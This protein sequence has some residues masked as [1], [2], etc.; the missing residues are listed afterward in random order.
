MQPLS[1]YTK[2]ELID[3]F[4]RDMVFEISSP[5]G[6]WINFPL[7]QAGYSFFYGGIIGRDK[8]TTT[9]TY[10]YGNTTYT[11]EIL[12]DS[13][14][15][16][17][18]CHLS[19]TFNNNQFHRYQMVIARGFFY[20]FSVTLQKNPSYRHQ[21]YIVGDENKK[22]YADLINIY[23]ERFKEQQQ[24]KRQTNASVPPT[25]QQAPLQSPPIQPIKS[26]P[27]TVQKSLDSR[28]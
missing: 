27:P 17:T 7:T 8:D 6:D 2:Q 21:S 26:R 15:L 3:I 13:V 25:P 1:E 10:P 16:T 28:Q 11:A 24:Q 4:N 12:Q 18:I 20:N 22:A 23:A 19:Y 9:I 14:S 5:V